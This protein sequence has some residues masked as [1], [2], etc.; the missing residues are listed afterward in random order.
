MVNNNTIIII[1][2]SIAILLVFIFD[3]F[4][5]S[6]IKNINSE[7]IVFDDYMN[8]MPY[9]DQTNTTTFDNLKANF[10][11]TNS[12][13]VNN[14]D[15]GQ[16]ISNISNDG[17]NTNV[18]NNLNA[19]SI[20]ANNLSVNNQNVG[21]TISNIS[22][23]GA[24]TNVTNNLNA[25]SITTNSITANILNANSIRTNSLTL[26]NQDIGQTISN[27]SNDGAN[28]NVTNNLNANSITTNSL[29][30]NNQDVG[31][32]ISNISNDGSNTNV[33]NNLNTNSVTTNNL[34]ANSITTNSL[35]VNN[36]DVGKT[37][38]N[39]SNDGSNTNVTNNLNVNG[40]LFVNYVKYG[41]PQVDV[42]EELYNFN[43]YMT[44]NIVNETGDINASGNITC[45]KL[46]TNDF[47]VNGD[48]NITGTNTCNK[49]VTNSISVSGDTDFNNLNVNGDSNTTG[50]NT[51]N[52]LIT[53]NIKCPTIDN[54]QKQ[55]QENTQNLYSS[56]SMF[57]SGDTILPNNMN[58]NQL[59][60][61]DEYNNES[62]YKI[63]LP[64]DMN[65]RR[66]MEI[67]FTNW[68]SQDLTIFDSVVN[69]TFI[70]KNNAINIIKSNG[71]L[72]EIIY[73]SSFSNGLRV[74]NNIYS[75]NLIL[76]GDGTNSYIKNQNQNNSL[77]LG[78]G[79]SNL[80]EMTNNSTFVN[81][82]LV[83][84]S[85]FISNNY[86]AFNGGESYPTPS[87]YGSNFLGSNNYITFDVTNLKGGNIYTGTFYAGT[88]LV[89]LTL[90][91][92]NLGNPGGIP[93]VL[94]LG[95]GILSYSNG[96]VW[97]GSGAISLQVVGFFSWN[98]KSD[99]NVVTNIGMVS[100]GPGHI[101]M[102]RIA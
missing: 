30:V 61:C 8:Q 66:G 82:N 41:Q 67:T 27:I 22:N 77:F 98:K 62:S 97:N 75:N 87:Y 95:S 46:Y 26:N 15:V 23:D 84:N 48:S 93:F 4:L 68:S 102:V 47:S 69:S 38:S 90:N 1:F 9:N 51:C 65:S 58:S 29:S 17:Y 5:S 92:I 59:I 86:I 60:Q 44:T 74:G 101:Q 24:N 71:V 76:Q 91:S 20:T 85:G 16:T 56:G 35:S 14:Q 64:A 45:N 13:S 78:V 81:N 96:F 70:L 21:Q 49:L 28:T 53:N 88:Y 2:I 37:I 73:D 6:N 72:N 54:L 12:L 42:A 99:L 3:V 57:I 7:I 19:N 55:V 43:L 25:N 63:T 36:Q 50:N 79:N 11:I 40:K 34:N 18:T 80:L 32:T 52:N 89:I 94:T 39:I 83:C 10:I 33:T 100:C 31:K